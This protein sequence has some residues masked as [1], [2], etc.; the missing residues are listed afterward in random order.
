MQGI[1]KRT[2]AEINLDNAAWNYQQIRKQTRKD[3]KVCCVIKAN[4]YGHNAVKLASLYAS[5]GA[6]YLA[7]SNLEEAVQLREANI[8]LPIL[9]LGYTPPECADLLASHHISQCV[10]SRTYGEA[11]SQAAMSAGVRVHIHIKIDTG[12]GRIGFQH[13]GGHSELSD[14]NAVCHL[15]C[16]LTEGIFT[17]F[18]SADEGE[19]GEAYTRA[20][21]AAF[22]EAISYLESKGISFMIRHCANSA[23]IFDYPE[24]HLDMVRAGAGACRRP[25][26]PARLHPSPCGGRRVRRPASDRPVGPHREAEADPDPRHLRLRPVCRRN[27]QL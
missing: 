3:A 4:A 24:F 17:H 27:A 1:R 7:V 23:A 13:H 5:L 15:P 11:L 6:D 9:I 16:L 22:E 10:Y 18:A 8:S 20:Q 12:M 25:R 14:A 19:A 26:R 2:W 21:F